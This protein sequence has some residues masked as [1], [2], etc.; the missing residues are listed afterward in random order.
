MLILTRKPGESVM[1]EESVRIT[2]LEVR[3]SQVKL[4]IQAPLDV[5]V[6]REEVLERQRAEAGLPPIPDLLLPP[7]PAREAAQAGRGADAAERRRSGSGRTEGAR[8]PGR[9]GRD[10]AARGYEAS[11]RG[12]RSARD[13]RAERDGRTDH[14]G[15]LDREPRHDR[16]GRHERA[17]HPGHSDRSVRRDAGGRPAGGLGSRSRNGGLSD[18]EPGRT[19]P[20]D[21]LG[22]RGSP[23]SRQEE[24]PLG[25][26]EETGGP[27]VRRYRSPDGPRP[28][29]AG[30]LAERIGGPT[31]PAGRG[32]E[33]EPDALA[34]D[35]PPLS[36]DGTPESAARR[37]RA[38]GSEAA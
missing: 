2:V 11:A 9:A 17:A 26:P 14:S 29:R 4:G 18:R 28:H 37:R 7:A 6:N 1:I 25:G 10:A 31:A 16:D 20:D 34:P 38:G 15:R 33:A 36:E 35:V 8:L 19:Q 32:P 5:R 23:R 22:L 24:L 3:G 13:G 27:Q 21:R 12:G 30:R